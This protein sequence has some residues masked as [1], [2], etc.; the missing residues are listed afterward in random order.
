MLKAMKVTNGHLQ[1]LRCAA[2]FREIFDDTESLCKTLD[3][4]LPTLPRQRRP[5]ARFSGPGAA[6]QAQRPED[7][8]RTQYFQCID[9]AHM[10]LKR[11][12]DQP[13]LTQ[14]SALEK[15]LLSP[16]SSQADRDE[17]L[18]SLQQYPEIDCDRFLVQRAMFDQQGYECVALE[19][20]AKKLASLEAPVRSLF[21]QVETLDKNSTHRASKQCR[22]RTQFLLS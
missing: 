5:P 21:H 3:L 11:R 18:A 7:Y 16:I 1:G 4:P 12:Y 2:K 8:Y 19:D 9:A 20:V 6:H 13:G 17:A 14:Y 15:V 10:A 22:S